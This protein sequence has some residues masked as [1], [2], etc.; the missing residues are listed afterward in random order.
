MDG[1]ASLR[2]TVSLNAVVNRQMALFDAV[3]V[4]TGPDAAHH[5]VDPDDVLGLDPLRATSL[6]DALGPVAAHEL[7]TWVLALPTPGALGSLRGPRELN[8]AALEIGEA[9]VATTGGLGLVPYRVGQGVQWRVFRA[10]QPFAPP[11]P[12][13]AERQLNEAVISAANTLT[14]LD[15]G[16]GARPKKVPTA[17]LAP[18]YSARQQATA[19]RAARLLV[20]CDTALTSDGASISAFE[21]DTR[22]RELR[23]VRAAAAQALCAAATWIEVQEDDRI[24]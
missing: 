18:G 7:Q 24:R 22:F 1:L 21:A 12:Y 8:E 19:D 9:V 16:A 3:T 20:A 4:V 5:V 23:T 17:T 10:E 15:V 2:M 13:D 14:R 11:V 6:A